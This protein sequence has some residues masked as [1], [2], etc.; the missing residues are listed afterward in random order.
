M[1]NYPMSI[2]T[3]YPAAYNLCLYYQLWESFADNFSWSV[4]LKFMESIFIVKQLTLEF[5][6]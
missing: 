2:Q 1:L 3:I 4:L 6:F 5:A